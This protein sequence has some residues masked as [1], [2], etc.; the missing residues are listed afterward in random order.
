MSTPKTIKD[1]SLNGKTVFLRV[2]LNSEIVNGKPV[3][4]PRI[5][6]H[7][8][9]IALLKK[10]KAK[11]IVIAHQSRPG[12]K[13]FTSLKYHSKLLKKYTKITFIQDVIGKKAEAAINN[14][15][16]GEAI[17]LENIRSLKEE[18]SNS[19]NNKLVNFFK[20]KIDVYINDAFSIS[21]REQSSLTIIPKIAKQKA[22]GPV[23]E[24]E[25]KNI[26]KLDTKDSLYILGGNKIKD[27]ML[28]IDK[29]ILST[30]LFSIACLKAKG[31]EF[32]K[33][34]NEILKEYNALLPKIK[35]NLSHIKT[36]VDLALNINGK[37]KECMID[38]L[39]DNIALDIGEKTIQ[40]YKSEINK[41]KKI[42][43]KGTAGDCSKKAFSKG[44][45]ELLKSMEKSRA[46]C[47]IAGGHSQ[48]ALEKYKINKNKIGYLSL[49]GGALIH[50]I[51]GKKLP[52]L[53][54]LK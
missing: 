2:D 53:E 43:W 11:I 17:L 47:V 38:N 49:S 5:T 27:L 20:D 42:L 52:G 4:S 34:Q 19:K 50:Y 1:I 16:P 14:L 10:K 51:S 25:L 3:L 7:A 8:K 28:L 30:G 23:F 29:N 45:I 13:D 41:S 6:E 44:T 46:F 40:Y 37:R 15:K 12:K 21:H 54:A 48:T 24:K 33:K 26:I 18:Y 9:T 32:G 35:K 22:M 31:T 39:S 36:P